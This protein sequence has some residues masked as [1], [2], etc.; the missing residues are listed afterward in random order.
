MAYTTQKIADGLRVIKSK[1]E[2]ARAAGDE[3]TAQS[4][5]EK[6][7]ILK[8]AYLKLK[9]QPQEVEKAVDTQG[10]ATELLFQ[11]GYKE[12]T[13][14][15][16][17][18]EFTDN[19]EQ[20]GARVAREK[21][22]LMPLLSDAMGVPQSEIDIESGLPAS[23]RIRMGLMRDDSQRL[24]YLEERY[25][26]G[27]VRPIQMDGRTNFM[28]RH[29]EETQNKFV[30]SDEYAVTLRDILDAGRGVVSGAAET[31]AT[32]VGPG[33]ASV[34]ASAAKA[35]L[36]K[37]V[38]ALGIDTL[39]GDPDK[40]EGALINNIANAARE[41]GVAGAMDLG[42]G[43]ILKGGVKAYDGFKAVKGQDTQ[44]DKFRQAKEGIEREY[45]IKFPETSATKAGT[46]DQI[47]KQ[48][49]L[50]A[51]YPEGVLAT[52][53]QKSEAARDIIDRLTTSMLNM[54]PSN[55]NKMYDKWA[56]GLI[57]GSRES[58]EKLK[59]QDELLGREAE[60]AINER[61]RLLGGKYGS[62]TTSNSAG[63]SVRNS[64]EESY[65]LTKGQSDALYQ[66]VFDL[67]D[68][69]GVAVNAQEVSNRIRKTINSLD[70]P[71]DTKGEVLDIFKPKELN[72]ASRQASALGE[73]VEEVSPEILGPRGEL[74]AGGVE[75]FP[76]VR[77]LNLRQLDD[78]RKELNNVID[79]AV[80]AGKDTSKLRKVQSQVESIIDSAMRKGGDDV[81]AANK[82]AKDFF[83]SNILPFRNEGI[84][85]LTKTGKGGE[86]I[87]SDQAVAYRFFRSTDAVRNIQ[88]LK[89]VIGSDA[90]SLGDLR[91]AYLHELMDKAIDGAGNVD[92]LKLKNVAYNKEIA[93]E[94]FGEQSLKAFDELTGLM[95]I[96]GAEKL[97]PEIIDRALNAR[98]S[99]DIDNILEMATAQIRQQNYH[100]KVYAPKLIKQII[101]E[102]GTIDNPLDLLHAVR[103]LKG[104]Q[105]REFM[106]RIPV[107]G[108]LREAFRQEFMSDLM[109]RAGRE[110]GFAQK[111]SRERGGKPLWDTTLMANLLRDKKTRANAEAIMGKITVNQ[112]E[113]LNRVLS[114]YS[115]KEA[116]E[117]KGK[118]L[119]RAEPG[120]KP[121]G[122]AYVPYDYIKVRLL[123]AALGSDTLSKVI[124]KS[125]NSDE[126]FSRLFPALLASKEGIAALT[127]E[128]DKDPRFEKYINDY[129]YESPS[130]EKKK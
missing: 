80:K 111:T 130:T 73:T 20:S 79:R 78:Y 44:F 109:I 103:G 43:T 18:P 96:R 115:R 3:S 90:A 74:L 58:I 41:G 47:A 84:G 26:G 100:D 97:D 27:E 55:F 87:A 48:E 53:A 75:E 52:L 127:L 116:A 33:K 22:R 21:E 128:A 14:P 34:V 105:A 72:R 15:I 46:M 28:V 56:D 61:I 31:G 88:Q 32:L 57:R 1:V 76:G 59:Q 45:G 104:K 36:G 4:F 82:E 68:A 112:L 106:N 9:A 119:V 8:G 64:I 37:G 108:G 71:K 23:V 50:V 19:V 91:S 38:S 123:S 81:V 25:A 110:S 39:F 95:K 77:P 5:L 107:E 65:K 122:I 63:R 12:A 86:Y 94:L 7:E 49:K 124:T 60:R 98:S 40:A 101:D 17:Y 6:A 30:L 93:K 29:P 85:N 113:R 129:I 126:L 35:G 102:K 67:A 99:A 118:A 54:K 16:D 125:Q 2:E 11:G 117:V 70:L 83:K 69:R 13:P 62:D 66:R 10:E 121:R 114:G 51:K 24:N 42:F 92:W 120:E 89:R